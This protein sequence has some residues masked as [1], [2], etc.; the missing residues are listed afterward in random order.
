MDDADL[1]DIR[2]HRIV[3]RPTGGRASVRL[4]T[5]VSHSEAG[6]QFGFLP[7]CCETIRV[8]LPTKQQA[9][10]VVVPVLES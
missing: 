3:V 6:I 4:P 7:F 5:H 2:K 8:E 1:G 10:A 9:A